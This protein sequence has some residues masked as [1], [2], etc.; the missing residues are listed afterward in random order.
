MQEVSN[1]TELGT[2]R[3]VMEKEVG[4]AQVP[5]ET[6]S[7]NKYYNSAKSSLGNSRV[8]LT[9]EVGMRQVPLGADVKN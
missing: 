4:M 1:M 3:T 6:S 8:V 2:S 5:L 9:K 7:G